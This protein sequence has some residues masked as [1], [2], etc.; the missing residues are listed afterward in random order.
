MSRRKVSTLIDFVFTAE[1]VRAGRRMEH[2]RTK[3]N[4]APS[5]FAS[6]PQEPAYRAA[7]W[8]PEEDQFLRKNLGWMSEADIATSLGR[9]VIA[10]HLR[11]SR[12]LHLPSPS[13]HPDFLTAEQA[14]VIL[15]VENHAVSH[16]CDAGLIP[17]RN[18]AAN[19]KMRLIFR[20]SFY[21]WVLTP[22]NWIY[23][24]YTK[25]LD[26]HLRRLC[27]LRAIR[28]GD[29]WMTTPQVAQMHGVT[30]KDVQRL[31]YR[32]EL[33]AVQVATSRGGR[34]KNPAWL[35]WY[36]RRSDAENARFIKGRGRS[37]QIGWQPTPRA[38]AW[39]KK[40]WKKGMNFSQ[41]CRSMGN[42]VTPW[43]LRQY[44]VRNLKVR[45]NK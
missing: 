24:D 35:N 29:E 6:Q 31:V 36:V 22:D 16:W 30:S 38:I 32:G 28:W 7:R 44:M 42:P 33:P 5:I 23:F 20:T 34:N 15:N 8:T 13:K 25:I 14:S 37:K 12:D 43:S 2:T 40:A 17:F 4:I 27:E 3:T 41:I 21:R 9:T 1:E 10:V 18:M 11:W 39:M 45:L 19:R 26:P